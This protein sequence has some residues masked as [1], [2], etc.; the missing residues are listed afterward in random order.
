MIL[1][2]SSP[3]VC[4]VV[5][6]FLLDL[7]KPFRPRNTLNTRK[8]NFGKVATVQRSKPKYLSPAMPAYDRSPFRV[9]RGQSQLG[10]VVNHF[11]VKSQPRSLVFFPLRFVGEDPAV[12]IL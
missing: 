10:F 2:K 7:G 4:F 1:A 9:F 3:F 11:V 8:Q 12:I 5:N 6:Q